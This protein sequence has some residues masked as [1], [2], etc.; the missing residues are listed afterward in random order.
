VIKRPLKF[1]L[2]EAAQL[3]HSWTCVQQQC[4]AG[5]GQ[6]RSHTDRTTHRDTPALTSLHRGFP[7][8]KSAIS[9]TAKL[10]VAYTTAL[11][12]HAQG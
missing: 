6:W 12:F 2:V 11:S 4:V 5:E 9:M 7:N 8:I 3:C 10:G 1:K